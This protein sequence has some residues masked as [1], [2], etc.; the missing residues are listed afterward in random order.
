MNLPAAQATHVSLPRQVSNHVTG[1]SSRPHTCFRLH[2]ASVAIETASAC[3][4]SHERPR[5]TRQT[6]HAAVGGAELARRTRLADGLSS[7][8]LKATRLTERTDSA[9]VRNVRGRSGRALQTFASKDRTQVTPDINATSQT[10]ATFRHERAG[11]ASLTTS[12]P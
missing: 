5:R 8:A 6:R 11:C 12:L 7:L 3:C 9:R 2:K 4:R 1:F 10:P